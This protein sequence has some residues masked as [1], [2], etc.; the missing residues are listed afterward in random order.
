MAA[1]L[2]RVDASRRYERAMDEALARL[3][4]ELGA[5]KTREFR[6]SPEYLERAKAALNDLQREHVRHMV[7]GHPENGL[8]PTRYNGFGAYV[9]RVAVSGFPYGE[10]VERWSGVRS[11]GVSE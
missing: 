3:D 2:R 4:A 7:H 1:R 10:N 8:R 5:V 6:P 9:E 11:G